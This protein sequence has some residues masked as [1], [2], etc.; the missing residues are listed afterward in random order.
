MVT[1]WGM[2]EQAGN[3]LRMGE[4]KRQS[5]DVRFRFLTSPPQRCACIVCGGPEPR[6][7]LGPANQ[8]RGLVKG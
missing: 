3:V 5:L 1:V 6:L 8:D 7:F 4:P 2:L